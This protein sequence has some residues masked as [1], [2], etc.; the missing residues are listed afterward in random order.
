M[1]MNIETI[2][3]I[4]TIFQGLALIFLFIQIRIIRKDFIGSRSDNL[5]YHERIKKQSTLEYAGKQWVDARMQLESEYGTDIVAEEDAKNIYQD[6]KLKAKVDKLLGTLEHIAAGVNS[7]IYDEDILYRMV[8][9]S[10][11][12]NFNRFKH[13]IKIRRQHESEEMYIELEALAIRFMDRR[14][15]KPMKL[16]DIIHS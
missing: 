16:G 14:S 15:K 2:Q 4:A 11:I 8:A 10:V 5:A 7:K 1:S 13:Y 12:D 3:L 9:S 6:M